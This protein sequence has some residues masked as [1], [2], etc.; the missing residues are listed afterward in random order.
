MPA[1]L[2]VTV[3]VLVATPSATTGPVPVIVE[4]AATGEPATKVTLP[5]V[6][7]TGDV[8]ARVFISAVVEASVQVETPDASVTEQAEAV[9]LEPVALKLGVCPGAGLFAASRRVMVMLEV[10]TPLAS[11]GDV[12][13]MLELAA[14][15][16]PGWKTTVPP[17]T[18]IG[19]VRRRV[20]V[21]AMVE[22]KVQREKPVVTVT[23]QAP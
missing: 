8:M 12:P 3:T 13:M 18:M 4:V 10:E 9:L 19:V 17:L 22:V 21:S 20:F 2:S 7:F 23:E 11:V 1:S 14:E 15:T 16:G 6:L 5:S